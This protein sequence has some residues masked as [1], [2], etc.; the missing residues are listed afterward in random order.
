MDLNKPFR[1]EVFAEELANSGL[2][3]E[4]GL[5]GRG[6]CLGLSREWLVYDTAP[7]GGKRALGRLTRKSITRLSSLVG[8][9]TLA[10]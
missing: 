4:N 1:V 5:V 7:P 8:K 10:N 3:A 6:L 9:A 2:D